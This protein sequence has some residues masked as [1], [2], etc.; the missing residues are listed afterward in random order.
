[1]ATFFDWKPM[2]YVMRILTV[3]AAVA[4]VLAVGAWLVLS[5]SLLSPVRASIVER[6]IAQK[7]GQDVQIEGE[8]TVGLGRKLEISA[9]EI[10]FPGDGSIESDLASVETLGFDL[11]TRD[12]L[13]GKISISNLAIS[14]AQ[15]ALKTSEDGKT[16][17][18]SPKRQKSERPKKTT[19]R[20]PLSDFLAD[21]KIRLSDATI[22]YF[23]GQK[24][25]DFDI[26]L[27]DLVI[28]KGSPDEPLSA[29]GSGTVNGQ[30]FNLN[31]AYPKDKP[32]HV[33]MIFDHMTLN[34]TQVDADDGL[35]IE[36]R[37]DVAELGQLLDIMKLN[38]VL[39]GTG[40]VGATYSTTKGVSRIDDLSVEVDLDSGQ[41]LKLSGHLGK[42][43]D[44]SD[45]S[46]TTLISLYPKG[47]EPEP[48]QSRY[49]LKLIS[50]DMVM[51]SVPGQT[52]QRRMVIKTNG[53]TL[54]TSGEGPPPVKFSDIS[55]TTDSTLR[56]GSVA[57]RLGNPAHPFLTIDGSVTDA[58]QLLGI[59]AKGNL[60]LPTRSLLSSQL[61]KK[62]DKLGRLTGGFDL[63]GGIDQ[64]S[65][66]NLDSHTED[67]EVWS[68]KV[69]G[70]VKNVLTFEDLDL[71]IDVDVPS[72]AA[73]L[74]AMGLEPVETGT[75]TLEANL[76]SQDTDWDATAAVTVADS[77]LKVTADLDDATSDP[78]LHG[79]VESDLIKIDQLR[80]IVLAAAQ[81]RK[82]GESDEQDNSQDA[83]KNDDNTGPLRDVTLKPIGQA[84]L[85]SG[86]NM[87]IDV[88]LHHIE[89]AKGV[90]SIHSEVTLNK[91]ELKAGP[92]TF[93]YGDAH[94]DVHGAM[95]LT[96]ENHN[97]TVTGKAG[98]WQLEELLHQI[99]FKKGAS[100]T[101]YADFNVT[102]G[103]DSLQH[104]K[105]SMNGNATISLRN[106][107]VET[108]LLDIAGLGLLPW[109][110]SKDKQKVAPIV[111]L[112][113]PLTLAGGQITT[114]KTTLETDV[115]QVV[116][117]GD[118]NLKDKSIDLN[119]QP[120]KIGDPLS[121]SPWPV[122]VIGPLNK[123]KVKVKD[124]PKRL[125]RKDGAD[126]MPAH[127]E[128]CIPD[129]LQLQ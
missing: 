116:A 105:N 3:L 126:K 45:V 93:E 71:E 99:K 50:V 65:L 22:L 113:A 123:P 89:G 91:N 26:K 36:A 13:S 7:V 41:S 75:T 20:H 52:P 121:R 104:F 92:L 90:S 100:G 46:L 58:L 28:D 114:R 39:E 112:R 78:V 124:G 12:L 31:G 27:S 35:A 82:L 60:D 15:L 76:R 125:K 44:P 53:F 55:R 70:A 103:I 43:G 102:G 94:F 63:T 54:D 96:D 17:W 33:A 110:F 95:D 4:I 2:R 97:L 69:Q 16:S 109:V 57:L 106:G 88:D 61:S 38:R 51:D 11:S 68:L 9:S 56:V 118:V 10:V 98:G 67:T 111:C 8:L 77:S 14:G 24:G 120:R 72:G 129:I 42:L 6:L 85:L 47:S 19:A 74:E 37:A 73:L 128:P 122:T 21:G 29:K 40:K 79:K 87:D 127:R 59:S 117:F 62:D 5:S 83:E 119:L 66:A 101:I 107:S 23:N 25:W 81:L 49:D 108:Q 32:F 30:A 115:V 34:A 18:R 84:I 86:A 80:T 1:M 64:L 48:T